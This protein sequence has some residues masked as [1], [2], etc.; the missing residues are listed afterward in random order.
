MVSRSEVVEEVKSKWNAICAVVA[1]RK[2]A[3]QS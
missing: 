3:C 2:S 1:V